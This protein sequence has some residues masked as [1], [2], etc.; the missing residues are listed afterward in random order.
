MCYGYHVIAGGHVISILSK[1]QNRMR[2]F[3]QI[4]KF[5]HKGNDYFKHRS[6]LHSVFWD[7]QRVHENLREKER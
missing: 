7:R 5:K 1:Q 6:R 2:L 3:W 4:V